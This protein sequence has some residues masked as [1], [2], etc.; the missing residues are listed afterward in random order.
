MILASPP[1]VLRPLYI[2]HAH[3]DWLEWAGEGG[4]GFLAIWAWLVVR[5]IRKSVSHP[6][7]WGIAALFGHALVDFPLARFGVA[8]WA[9]ILIGAIESSDSPARQLKE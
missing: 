7:A 4:L 6:W 3:N 2:N 1:A 9:F 8:A 5:A